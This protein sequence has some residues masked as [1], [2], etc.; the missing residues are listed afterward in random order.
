MKYLITGITILALLL[1][2]CLL[3]AYLSDRYLDNVK[4]QLHDA[5]DFLPME[6]WD[7]VITCTEDA[8]DLWEEHRDFFSSLLDHSEL[9]DID[10]TF[11]SLLAYARANEIVSY[12]ETYTR[13]VSMLEH[14][15][16]MDDPKLYNILAPIVNHY[17]I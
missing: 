4:E 15:Q 17:H 9:E 6:D 13:L 8:E 11:I 1:S 2:L 5:A 10:R 12:Y 3:F 16:N 14:I 7:S